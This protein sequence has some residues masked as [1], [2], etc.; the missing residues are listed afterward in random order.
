MDKVMKGQIGKTKVQV[1]EEKYTN[2]GV[3]VWQKAN[4]KFFTDGS[5][6]I[7]NI[8]A[9]KDDRT[10]IEE[11][12]KAAAYYGESEGKAVF[13]PGTGRVSDEEHSEQVD[14]MSQ[15]LIPSMNDLGAII[16]AKAT[17]DEIG[18]DAYNA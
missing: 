3:Y 4:G 2:V 17:V 6:N 16:A 1:V 12:T 9:R 11:L 14:R 5:N 15:G 8:P 7:L 13:F 18:A 10:K